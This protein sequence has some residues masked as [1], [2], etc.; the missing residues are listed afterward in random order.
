MDLQE[1]A[2]DVE[3]PD[4]ELSERAIV[5]DS[6]SDTYR[7][8]ANNLAFL[9]SSAWIVISTGAAI[10][11]GVCA[12]F[13]KYGKIQM[14][15]TLFVGGA[16][17]SVFLGISYWAFLVERMLIQRMSSNLKDLADKL[18]RDALPSKGE[19]DGY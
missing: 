6:L 14:L 12:W 8:R 11:V 4:Q 19:K 3:L 1:Q 2:S 16:F 18:R 7:N 13:F 17:L 15:L 9:S 10:S 5:A